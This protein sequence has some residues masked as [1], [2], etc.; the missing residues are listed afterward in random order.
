MENITSNS[1]ITP[2]YTSAE[3]WRYHRAYTYL[4]VERGGI[5]TYT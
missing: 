1:T 3:T 2:T 4:I 5:K